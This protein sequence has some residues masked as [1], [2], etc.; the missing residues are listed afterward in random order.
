MF[1]EISWV[2]C[3]LENVF[4]LPV[5]MTLWKQEPHHNFLEN[6]L[7]LMQPPLIERQS[8]ALP[9]LLWAGKGGTADSLEMV[10]S[11]LTFSPCETL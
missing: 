6:Y 11:V 7:L 1:K 3:D 5:K 4:N 10:F 9:T 2:R 8:L